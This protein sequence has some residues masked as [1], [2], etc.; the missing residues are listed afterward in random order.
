MLALNQERRHDAVMALLLLLIAVLVVAFLAL[1]AF[2]PKIGVVPVVGYLILG[3]GV[4]LLLGDRLPG[5]EGALSV[6][7]KIGLVLLLFHI[8]LEAQLQS[9]IELLGKA[10]WILAIEVSVVG[11]TAWA[12]MA[13]FGQPIAPSLVV[14]VA[15]VA[16]SIG[17][18]T[19][20]WQ[21]LGRV[22][23][24]EGAL[25]LD[26][27]TLDDLAGVLLMTLLYGLLPY[28]EGGGLSFAN[29][30]WPLLGVAGLIL[31]CYLFSLFAEPP[32]L[33][34]LMK[35]EKRPDTMLTILAIGMI[36]ASIASLVH[37]SFA[38][39]AFFAGI[40]FSRDPKAVRLHVSMESLLD[41]FVPFFFFWIGYQTTLSH[42][43]QEWPLFLILLGV[44]LIAKLL[45]T[46]LPARW[47]GLS[48]KGSLLI[49]L[50]MLPRAEITM[51]VAEHGL[52]LGFIGRGTYS[53]ISLI[54][55]ISCLATS[56]L[57]RL[58]DR[59]AEPKS[60]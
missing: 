14:A 8:G 17:V 1:R 52:I 32:L 10:G 29:V 53:L 48:P 13:L 37:T 60:V 5:A 26:L 11:V 16:T 46:G 58:V 4:S 25:L 57:V 59:V 55:L 47:V 50:S 20:N 7:S 6:L 22:R 33:S 2:L 42:L 39:G 9:L 41:L 15:L 45:S 24:K 38:V 56:V 18:A 34:G 27:A 31:G 44:T 28:W 19:L 35:V 30:G 40:A 36:I 12:V 23:S 43:G 54:V 49:G 3:W 21:R 51:V